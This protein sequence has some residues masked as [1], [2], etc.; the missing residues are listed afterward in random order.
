[1]PNTRIVAAHLCDSSRRRRAARS[2]RHGME[3]KRTVL[4][5]AALTFV[6]IAAAGCQSGPRFAWWKNEKPPEDTSA[7]A[8]SATP[9]Q[10]AAQSKP[11]AVAIAGLTPAA[12]PSSMNLASTA[13]AAAT[14]GATGGLAASPGATAASPNVSIP[15]TT[16]TAVGATA[17]SGF[18]TENGLADKLVST[19]NSKSAASVTSLAGATAGMPPDVPTSS[20]GVPPAG[21]YDPNGY[22]RSAV[23]A[24]APA[25]PVE[26]R[27]GLGSTL[28]ASGT[29]SAAPTAP[30]ALSSDPADRY[31]YT[32]TSAQSAA[33]ANGT[34]LMDPAAV[35][36]DRYS[37]PNLPSMNSKPAPTGQTA[38]VATALPTNE[39]AGA[40]T[41]V[42]SPAPAVRLASAP[43]QYRP[44]RTSTYSSASGTN[45][46]E[47]ASRPAPAVSSGATPA[48]TGATAQPWSPPVATPPAAT[49][50]Y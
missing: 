41:P 29:N 15:V 45:A 43:G 5:V 2:F 18:P 46:V 21:P 42:G 34:P 28:A 6:A 24:A 23:A 17:N 16:P 38:T 14:A 1:M 3:M 10:P 32:P 47:I 31:G 40:T 39:V 22:K 11:E 50:T 33:A 13:P 12:S 4:Q 49:R 37:N 7:V 20:S 48:A 19:P 35:A 8:R 26:D 36:A 30:E 25:Q 9:A 27:Y 44:G